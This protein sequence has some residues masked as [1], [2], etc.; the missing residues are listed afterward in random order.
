MRFTEHLL[1]VQAEGFHP[2]AFF[3]AHDGLA[4]TAVSELL[5]LGYRIPEDVSVI[6]FGDYSAA[7][8]I[9]PHL[10]TVKVHGMQIGAGLVRILDDRINH[11]IEPD[12][13]L[14][15]MLASHIITRASSGPARQLPPKLR[16]AS[17]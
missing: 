6:G 9:T 11:R 1:K 14:R 5:H 10:T 12:V 2:T 3:C 13:P 7:T 16:A 8:Q 17:G 4:L 15:I